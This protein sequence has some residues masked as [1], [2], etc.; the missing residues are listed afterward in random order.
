[1]FVRARLTSP[2]PSASSRQ[3]FPVFLSTSSALSLR[4]ISMNGG[5]AF[6]LLDNA[7]ITLVPPSDRR[8][9]VYTRAPPSSLSGQVSHI[10]SLEAFIAALL[11]LRTRTVAKYSKRESS[12]CVWMSKSASSSGVKTCLLLFPALCLQTPRPIKGEV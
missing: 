9:F 6:V 7:G 11:K 12:N 5:V 1:M 3:L 4:C 2:S 10:R 8:V